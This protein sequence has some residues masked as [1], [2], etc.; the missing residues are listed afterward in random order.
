MTRRRQ[1]VEMLTA[2]QNRLSGL[3]GPAQADVEAHLEWLR[4]RVKQLDEQIEGQMQQ[5]QE[6]QVRHTG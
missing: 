5:C 6:W 1:L 3:R 2:E 4:E